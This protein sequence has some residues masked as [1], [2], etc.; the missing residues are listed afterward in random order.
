MWGDVIK[1]ISRYALTLARAEYQKSLKSEYQPCTKIFTATMGIP[2][3][4]T[5]RIMLENGTNFTV[6]DFDKYWWL[7]QPEKVTPVLHE[8][9]PVLGNLID[10]IEERYDQ[11]QLHQRTLFLNH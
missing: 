4:H 6:I 3:S 8:D 10:R 1:K 7:T 2:C 9:A 5:I 11:F